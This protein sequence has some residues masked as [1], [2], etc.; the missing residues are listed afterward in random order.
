MN[1]KIEAH[2]DYKFQRKLDSVPNWK[3]PTSTKKEIVD[4][5][6]KA[7]IGQV[8]EGKRLSGRT[9][10]K[11]LSLLKRC[12]EIVNKPTFKITK[13]DVERFDRE[14][15]KLE[16]KSIANYRVCLKTFLKWKLGEDRMRK[17]AG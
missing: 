3:V 11:N 14:L 1:I 5:T 4:F 17:L 15:V 8:N 7:A 16:L 2:G 12:L 6:N 10:S 9:L 13:E